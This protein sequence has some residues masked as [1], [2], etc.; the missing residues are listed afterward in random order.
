[1]PEQ[2]G[3]ILKTKAVVWI[4]P[5]GE[6]LPDESSVAAG[7]EWG[8]NWVKL[9]YTKESLKL[10]HSFSQH[11]VNV[12]QVLGAVK[13]FKTDEALMFETVLSEVTAL[14]LAYVTGGKSTDVATT[15][16]AAG[17]VGYEEL[18]VGDDPTLEEWEVGFEGE[19]VG[20]TGGTLPLRIFCQ[21][22]IILNGDLEFSKKNDD[23]T[24]IPIQI[25]ALADTGD[26]NRMFKFQRVTAAATS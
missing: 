16:A 14:N 26:S 20:A 23:H 21:G 18:N 19:R 5:K 9:G 12:E 22:N 2:V 11:V 25:A 24:G 13:R 8:G 1:M 4:A 15:P 6:S 3:D 10:K 7:A 17:Q